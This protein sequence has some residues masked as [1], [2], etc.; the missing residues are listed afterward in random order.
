M[1]Y[2]PISF[3]D[4]FSLSCFQPSWQLW[5]LR[6]I[7]TL[8]YPLLNPGNLSFVLCLKLISKSAIK[9]PGFT[10]GPV[11]SLLLHLWKH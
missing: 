3:L 1:L 8:S 11:S 7:V 10:D 5:Y 2:L 6:A 9:L 4:F